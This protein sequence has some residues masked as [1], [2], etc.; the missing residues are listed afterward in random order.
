MLFAFTGLSAIS[1]L[2]VEPILAQYLVRSAKSGKA[3]DRSGLASPPRAAIASPLFVRGYTVIPEPQKVT[4]SGKDFEFSPSWRLELA[5]GVPPDDIAVQ[6]LKQELQ[7]RFHLA[8]V[9]AKDK[10]G[11]GLKL[12]IDPQAVEIG[13]ATD[14]QKSVLAEQAY[15]IKLT[16]SGV[17]IIG[18]AASGL[19]YGVQ[20][21]VQ[22]LNPQQGQEWLP[23]GEVVDWPDLGL[24]V[25]Y[26]DDAHHLEHLEVLKGAIRQ[27]A[28]YKINGFSIKLEGHFEYRH[29]A[30][31][32][33]PYALSP[34]ELQELTDYALRYHVELIPYLDG[35]AHDAFILKHPEYAPLREYPESNYEFCVTNPETYKLF[36]GMFDDLLAATQ[37]SKY[38]LLSTDEPYYVGLAKNGQCNEAD[39]AKE[40]GS[41]GKLLAE[42]AT[43][44][45]GYLHQ[46]GRQVIFWG[47][48][49]MVPDDIASLPGYLI[50]G[51]VYGPKFD[52]VFKAHGIRQMI[53][54]STEGEEQ[55]FPEYYPL[56]SG[57]RLHPRPSGEGRVQDMT[58]S[59]SFTSQ[60]ALSS[61]QPASPKA[62]QADLMG[63]FVAGWGDPGLH[64]ETFWLGYATGPARGWRADSP[65]SQELMSTFY[66]LFYGSGAT[67]MGRLFQLMS[68]QARFWEDSWETGPS[69]ARS[70]IFGNS[71]GVFNPAHLAHDQYLPLLPVPSSDLLRLPYDWKVEN[72][73]RLDLAGR[74]L[75]QNDELINLI[76]ANLT[77]VQ[78]NRYNLEVYLSIANLYRQNLTMLREL[79]RM[80]DALGAAQSYAGQNNAARAVAALDRALGIAENIRQARNQVLNDA[81]ATWYKTWFPRVPE[82]NGRTFLD[83]VDD[84]KD[85]QPV[86]TVDMSYLV[87]RELL[88]PLGTWASQVT[89][90]RNKY[91][92]AHQLPART[93]VLNWKDTSSGVSTGRTPDEEEE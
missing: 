46:H 83:T 84:V 38:F 68:Q 45:A 30:A 64:P 2:A 39:R 80:V 32:V 47:E 24:R 86:R 76:N 35:P 6:S 87:Y 20:T 60:A 14:R 53:Y 18:N 82:A 12:A 16:P 52:P 3:N 72:Q 85:H 37:G 93:E 10:G 8:L 1:D 36:E 59:I 19:F 77:K 63:V 61:M 34:A 23:E 58:D 13:A 70:S 44:T 22:L 50:N 26:W 71:E 65:S 28:F 9:E 41:V 51:E 88:Y 33:E 57:E 49:P 74:F 92:Q 66:P 69:N 73:K 90:I 11:P 4:L 89:A 79:G 48:Y 29:A 5:P 75:A 78:F 62:D 55:L 54:T 56:P 43:K 25:I 21:L 81:T 31:M 42:F 27:A 7:E 17:T 91:A 67:D 15:R 40:L